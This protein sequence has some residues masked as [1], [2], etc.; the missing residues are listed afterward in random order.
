MKLFTTSFFLFLNVWAIGQTNFD[1]DAVDI[2]QINDSILIT[3]RCYLY[4]D[5]VGTAAPATIPDAAWIPFS[6]YDYNDFIPLKWITKKIFLRFTLENNSDSTAKVFFL[7]GNYIRSFKVYKLEA[8]NGAVELKNLSRGDGFQPF[9]MKA[10]EHETY[11]T[12]FFF[13]RRIHNYLI[14]QLIKDTYLLKYQKFLYYRND[15]QLPMGFLLSGI[16]L[17]MIFFTAAN[18][19]HSRKKEFLYNCCYSLCMF[20][21]IFFTTFVE[22]RGGV[23]ASLFREY[24]DFILLGGGTIFYIAFTRQFLETK[25]NYPLLNK[26]FVY[27]EKFLLLLL[28]M[29]TYVV[30]MTDNFLL[31]EMLENSMKI[32]VLI[33]GIV[34]IVIALSQKNKLMNYLAVGNVLLIFFSIISLVLILFPAKNSSIFSSSMVYYEIGVVSELICFLL[35]L[36]YKNRIELIEKTKEQESL[37]LEAEKLSFQTKLAIINAQQAERNRISADMHDDLGAGVTAI[38]LYSELA[39]K[40]VGIGTIPE[41]DKISS[42]ANDLLNNMNA[43]IWTMSS[44]NDTLDNMVAYIRSYALEYF[45][46]TGIGCYTKVD[47]DL[48]NIPVS[49][50]IRRNIY[51]V[52]KETLNNILK[53]AKAKEV[54]IS[55]KK[56][57][58]GLSLYIHDNGAGIDMNNLRRFGNGLINM[59]KRMEE[60][61]IT[62]GIENKNGTLVTLHYKLEL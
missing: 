9:A 58:G 56:V 28:A 2:S 18:Y 22:K 6:R 53:H 7:P 29:F 43:I 57:P 31:Q 25:K 55:L 40:K 44:S 32:I 5:S 39:K 46:N 23:L 59:K 38:R 51:L 61:N 52:V 26:I 21:L 27:E 14:P 12:E 11:V 49:G 20:V 54:H 47:E 30:F 62:F 16:L 3:Q 4:V 33:V 45:E 48:P 17:M 15:G 37:K 36:T 10:N 1:K 13:T 8:N 42:S 34:Y 41:I 60:S 35:G 24:F 19:M 50:E